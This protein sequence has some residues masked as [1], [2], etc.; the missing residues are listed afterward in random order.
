MIEQDGLP[1][2]RMNEY[3]SR[4]NKAIDHIERN[5]NR[6]LSLDE[7]AE[8]ACFS[9]FHFHRI[10]FAMT[11]ETLG[12]FIS[13]LRVEKAAGML[14]ADQNK[15][16]TS[17]ALDCGF[18]DSAVFARTFKS[19]FNVPASEWRLSRVT[20]PE[21]SNLSKANS[22]LSKEY[23]DTF[24]YF[25][26][27]NI[28]K[29][30]RKTM[31]SPK[32]IS[33]SELGEMTLAY[34]RYIGPYKGNSDLFQRLNQQL[35]SWAYP[36]GLVNYPETKNITVYHDDPGIT[37]EDKLRISVGIT[38]PGDTEVSGQ[39]GKMTL[40]K[41]QYVM[42]RFEIGVT[43]FQD[44]WNCLCGWFSTSGYQPADGPSFE[45]YYNDPREHPEHKFIL[46]ICMPVKP[47]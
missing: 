39:I 17:I 42:A 46:D 40:A 14:A 21:N 19:Y 10:F 37:E 20:E 22:N 11:G 43:Q 1:Q 13:R 41:G 16:I 23:L 35:M 44:A 30:R 34:V 25:E 8:V 15:S 33:V 28:T 26:D 9:K 47:L 4:I 38:V 3:W 7:I 31:T 32:S 36:R 27:V 29:Q 45:I 2:Y 6:E 12:R 24:R 5:L 18:S